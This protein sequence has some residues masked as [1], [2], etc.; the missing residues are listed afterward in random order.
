[1]LWCTS[2]DAWN[3]VCFWIFFDAL[4]SFYGW[5]SAFGL[6]AKELPAN[7]KKP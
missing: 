1:M 7:P 6:L 3:Q 4:A 5:L 2:G